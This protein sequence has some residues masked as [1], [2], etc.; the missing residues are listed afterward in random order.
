MLFRAKRCVVTLDVSSVSCVR[1]CHVFRVHCVVSHFTIDA[2]VYYT[3]HDEMTRMLRFVY[4]V[5]QHF[6]F[7]YFHIVPYNAPMPADTSVLCVDMLRY[8]IRAYGSVAYQWF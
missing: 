2:Q 4:Y 7:W 8:D 6:A 3:S 1:E 5:P